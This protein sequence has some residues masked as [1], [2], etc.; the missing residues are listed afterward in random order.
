MKQPEESLAVF[1]APPYGDMVFNGLLL[2]ETIDV[3]LAD[4]YEHELS[5]RIYPESGLVDPS[6]TIDES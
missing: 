1:F 2:E 4:E 6:P 5:F 3:V